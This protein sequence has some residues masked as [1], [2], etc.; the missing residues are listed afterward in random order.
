MGCS[1]RIPALRYGSLLSS[2]VTP[3]TR[4]LHDGDYKCLRQIGDRRFF[5]P[6]IERMY[7]L[8]YLQ[9][10]FVHRTMDWDL[11]Q[12]ISGISLGRLSAK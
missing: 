10:M 11:S 6:N 7:S 9:H 12:F 4:I 2:L 8:S 5:L 1:R 3:L